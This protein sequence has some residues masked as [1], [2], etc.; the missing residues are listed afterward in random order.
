MTQKHTEGFRLLHMMAMGIHG[1]FGAIVLT[2][3]VY[4]FI[5]RNRWQVAFYLLVVLV[6]IGAVVDHLEDAGLTR[7]ETF[8]DRRSESDHDTVSHFV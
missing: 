2:I 4:N 1:G 8:D 7:K 6:E 5:R 3:L